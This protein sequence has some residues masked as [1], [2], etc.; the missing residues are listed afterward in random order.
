M[1]I[2]NDKHRYDYI[3]VYKRQLYYSG[4]RRCGSDDHHNFNE[5]Y[6]D[7]STETEVNGLRLDKYLKVSRLIKRRT[8]L[9]YTSRCV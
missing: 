7:S 4:A 1:S 6:A 9:L 3:D 5:K 8:C 2:G